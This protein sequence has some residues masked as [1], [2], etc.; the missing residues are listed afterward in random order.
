MVKIQ[1]PVV[2]DGWMMQ[3]FC[4]PD[5]DGKKISL[6]DSVGQNGTVVAFIC[7]HCPY[8]KEII[9][10]FCKCA[11]KLQ[12]LGVNVVAVMPNDFIQY[13]QDSPEKMKEFAA[14]HLFSFP[15]LVDKSQNVAKEYDAVCTPDFFGFDGKKQLRYR[16]C[17]INKKTNNED[18]F[19]AMTQIVKDGCASVA[20][21]PS[22]GCSI[23]WK[24]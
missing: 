9:D 1:T 2:K 17:F 14:E 7:N 13:P 12:K 5:F 23:K 18:L 20:Q 10:P 11:Q 19:D 21:F 3:E 4:L 6:F 24:S 8:V 16:G 22:I 15:Y